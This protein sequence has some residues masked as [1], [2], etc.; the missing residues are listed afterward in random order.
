MSDDHALV[1]YDAMCRAIDAAYEIDEVKEIR[2]KA[3][4]FEMYSRLAHNVENERRACEIRLRAERKAGALLKA[5]E[6]AKAGRPAKNRSTDTT[7]SRT[8]KELGV[9]KDQSSNWQKLAA[10]PQEQFDAALGDKTVKPTTT[11]IIRANAEPKPKVTPVDED[12]L[13]LWGRL[14]EFKRNGIL[15]EGPERS[16]GD[17]DPAYVRPNARVGP[18]RE[19]VAEPDRDTNKVSDQ[20]HRRGAQ[21][22]LQDVHAR[23]HQ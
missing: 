6:K 15:R 3:T 4:A 9:T 18:E 13:W 5:I 17:H 12:A 11:S 10:V 19:A 8:L 2:D 22:E 1:K 7:N 14:C 21:A 23:G 20:T 16:H